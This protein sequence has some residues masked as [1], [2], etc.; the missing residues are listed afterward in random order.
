MII[1]VHEDFQCETLNV[2]TVKNTVR[3]QI[4]LSRLKFT[5]VTGEIR[6]TESVDRILK[7][8]FKKTMSLE[9]RN[10]MKRR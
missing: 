1:I 4:H 9:V 3:K 5:M 10:I 2:V 8:K 7:T 6:R